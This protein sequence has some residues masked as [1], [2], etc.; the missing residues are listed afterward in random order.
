[1]AS[2]MRIGIGASF[3][4]RVRSPKATPRLV[5][6]KTSASETRGASRIL[7][8]DHQ[9]QSERNSFVPCMF[10]PTVA[11]VHAT[12]VKKLQKRTSAHFQSPCDQKAN[13]L[14]SLPW[15]FQYNQAES[16]KIT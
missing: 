16:T 5:R 1:M 10:T 3:K 11:V 14:A 6:M 8:N 9:D 2:A 7:P 15:R 13:S 4:E 12:A